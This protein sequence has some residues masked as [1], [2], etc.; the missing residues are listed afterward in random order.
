MS[1]P[2]PPAPAIT[3]A[4][5]GAAIA[6]IIIAGSSFDDRDEELDANMRMFCEGPAMVKALRDAMPALAMLSPGTQH[7][8]DCQ[9]DT[10]L[11]MRR[12]LCRIDGEKTH[13]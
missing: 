1:I 11:A 13:G 2:A 7:A 10:I 5:K 9:R 12:I 4:K 3:S 6:I 8:A